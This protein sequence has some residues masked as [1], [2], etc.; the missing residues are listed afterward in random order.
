MATEEVQLISLEEQNF[1]LSYIAQI[2]E[3]QGK[4]EGDD[5]VYTKIP[6]GFC[7]ENDLYDLDLLFH[8]IS[9]SKQPEKT[10]YQPEKEIILNILEQVIVFEL[11][12]PPKKQL[13][14]AESLIRISTL[15]E[16][17]KSNP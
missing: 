4:E 12:C 7:L 16:K 2:N 11:T 5:Y 9:L 17:L 13:I 14:Q 8:P 15:F 3:L 10:R 6:L 1:I